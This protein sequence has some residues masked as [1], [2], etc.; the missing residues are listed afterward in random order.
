V[1]QIALEGFIQLFIE[2]FE[3]GLGFLNVLGFDRSKELLDG[4]FQVALEIK[5]MG[6]ARLVLAQIFDGCS[7]LWHNKAPFGKND[8]A[9]GIIFLVRK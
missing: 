4:F 2:Q 9:A 8:P 3:I 5:V 6:T 7:S 1:Q